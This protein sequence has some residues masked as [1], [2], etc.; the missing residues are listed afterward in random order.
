M[1]LSANLSICQLP[2][3]FC[4]SNV[5]VQIPNC[6]NAYS[7]AYL[8]AEAQGTTITLCTDQE[9]NLDGSAVG[10]YN[11]TTYYDDLIFAATL[12]YKASGD[13]AYLADAEAFYVKYVY[14]GVSSCYHAFTVTQWLGDS[15]M[16]W[17]FLG[18]FYTCLQ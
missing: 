4:G 14:G 12:L 2:E 1:Y 16:D 3:F 5:Q 6:P 11:D 15:P 9:K 7:E 13:E 10:L 18:S 17:F 8:E